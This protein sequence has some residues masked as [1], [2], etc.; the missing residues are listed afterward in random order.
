MGE[1][2]GLEVLF[3]VAVR[4][5]LEEHVNVAACLASSE[6][7]GDIRMVYLRGYFDFSFEQL[8]E[9]GVG[10]D[11]LDGD[12]LDGQDGGR[13]SRKVPFV[14]IPE[15]TPPQ[16]SLRNSVLVHLF[17]LSVETHDY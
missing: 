7:A 3:E 12:H 15:R 17:N 10:G 9:L 6:H 5:V 14:D 13:L 4:T 2:V 16:Q 8:E 11:L 1:A